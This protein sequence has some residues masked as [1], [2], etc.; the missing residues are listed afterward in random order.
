M[1]APDLEILSCFVSKQ[2][3]YSRSWPKSASAFSKRLIALKAG[4][5]TQ[6]VEVILERGKYRK[7]TINKQPKPTNKLK[8]SIFM[9]LFSFCHLEYE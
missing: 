2:A 4:L 1:K 5:R 7:I 6:G 9:F 8:L 3:R